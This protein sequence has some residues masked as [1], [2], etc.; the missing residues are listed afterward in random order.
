MS[1][2]AHNHPNDVIVADASRDAKARENDVFLLVFDDVLTDLN[3]IRR[4]RER[5]LTMVR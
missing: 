3:V 5:G 2:V 1:D 4:E